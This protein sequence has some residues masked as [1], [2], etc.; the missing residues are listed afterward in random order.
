MRHA[1]SRR[2]ASETERKKRDTPRVRVDGR[3]RMEKGTFDVDVFFLRPLAGFYDA[4]VTQSKS[5]IIITGCLANF[6]L[7][8]PNYGNKV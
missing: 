4:L 8:L 6:P 5:R 7:V 1:V 2:N 3:K